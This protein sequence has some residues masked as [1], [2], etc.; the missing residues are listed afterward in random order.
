MTRALIIVDVQNDFCEGGSLAVTGGHAVDERLAAYVAS[1]KAQADYDVLVTTQDWHIHPGAHFADAPDYA[2]SW[3]V[4]CVA[5][6]LG[7][8][9]ASPLAEALEGRVAG[10][11][12]KGMEAAAY[13]GFEG[14][15]VRSGAPLGAFLVGCD[16]VDVCGLATDYCVK[17]TALDAARAGFATGVRLDLCAGI[18]PA[19]VRAARAEFARAGIALRRGRP[20]HASVG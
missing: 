18:S 8:A 4:H 16:A 19:G 9:I 12:H 11:F 15:E 5:D 13:S 1:G 6:T 17:A 2:D 10:Q 20:R 3:P 14:E 7:A